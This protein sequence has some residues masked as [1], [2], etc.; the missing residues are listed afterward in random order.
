M[1][2][3][4]YKQ[5]FSCR[6]VRG[7]VR[8]VSENPQFN[9]K[10][11]K[12]HDWGILVV[13]LLLFTKRNSKRCTVSGLG[14]VRNYEGN[15]PLHFFTRCVPICFIILVLPLSNRNYFF[16]PSCCLLPTIYQV[17]DVP[18]WVNLDASC[19]IF[20]EESRKALKHHLELASH[21]A[22]SGILLDL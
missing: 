13:C 9:K 15:V 16:L 12:I 1:C 14:F 19:P 21:L 2:F 17:G 7:S 10:N 18:P 8:R 22:L 4:I 5:I 3:I 6:S 11:L 20:R